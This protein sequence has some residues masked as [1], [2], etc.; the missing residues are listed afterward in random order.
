MK[1]PSSD[2]LEHF[3]SIL[4]QPVKRQDTF[5]TKWEKYKGKD[6]LPFWIADMDLPTAPFI[7]DAV[8]QR[9][10]NG[11]LGYTNPPDTLLDSI[12]AYMQRS[13]NWTVDPRWVVF[14]PGVV[15]GLNLACQCIGDAGDNI[16]VPTPVYHHCFKAPTN[17]NKK[18]ILIPCGIESGTENDQW[19]INF[20]DLPRTLTNNTSMF[21]LCNPQ[22]PTGRIY[23]KKELSSIAD[24]CLQHNITIC[25][26]EIHAPI[27]LTD[28]PH[29]PIA[30]LSKSLE[31]NSISL[32]SHTKAYNIAGLSSAFAVIPN[33]QIRN[34]FITSGKGLLSSASPLAYAAAQAAYRDTTPW[35]KALCQHL[36]RNH[37]KLQQALQ[38]IAGIKVTHVEA[39][40]LAWID[41]TGLNLKQPAAAYF[42]Q[43]GLGFSCGSDFYGSPTFI[44]WNFACSDA[45]LTKGIE[46][47]A[48][49]CHAAI[50]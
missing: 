12:V 21:M 33:L 37:T 41:T 42:E 40:Y 8:E 35:L 49:A 5:S 7:I 14:L 19:R 25:S 13:Y 11:I 2:S 32:F 46:R 6:I 27:R 16:L 45:M 1:T 24:F 20:E 31:N 44:R 48:E 38:A 50:A 15:P 36:K 39:T 3:T 47:F 26:D 43:H 30:S 22:N 29:I 17:Q 23:T 4:S 28:Q 34:R 10:Q 9:L 18:P